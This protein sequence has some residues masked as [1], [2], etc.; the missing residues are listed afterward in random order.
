MYSAVCYLSWVARLKGNEPAESRAGEIIIWKS[1]CGNLHSRAFKPGRD[2]QRCMQRSQVH[3]QLQNHVWFSVPI[4]SLGNARTR[5]RVR[6]LV[7]RWR[8]RVQRGW[9]LCAWQIVGTH[10]W[11]I[12]R[13]YVIFIFCWLC[14]ITFFLERDGFRLKLL[15]WCENEIV[16][17]CVFIGNCFYGSL[18]FMDVII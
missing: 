1:K 3:S 9:V 14:L 13:F 17:V 11:E 5:R 16:L 7:R 4:G 18:S 10:A 6:V 15:F 8:L 12:S 2:R